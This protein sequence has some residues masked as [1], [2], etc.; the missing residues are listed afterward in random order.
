MPAGGFTDG[1]RTE[2]GRGGNAEPD[3][4]IGSDATGAGGEVPA[5][6]AG[7]GA[8][9]AGAVGA[10]AATAAETPVG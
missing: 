1:G 5:V 7:V 6:A 2:P 9:A 8:A 3:D 4:L 10:G